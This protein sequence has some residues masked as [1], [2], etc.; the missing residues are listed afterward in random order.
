MTTRPLVTDS[1]INAAAGF[2]PDLADAARRARTVLDANGILPATAERI[3]V[4]IADFRL[5]HLRPP[6]NALRPML[7]GRLRV[8]CT[9]KADEI[10]RQLSGGLYSRRLTNEGWV[11][12]DDSDAPIRQLHVYAV[13][14]IL[15]FRAAVSARSVNRDRDADRLTA[16]CIAL[17]NDALFQDGRSHMKRTV[18]AAHREKKKRDG[19]RGGRPVTVTDAELVQ[20]R[21]EF[22][23]EQPKA[24][25]GLLRFARLKLGLLSKAL[26]DKQLGSRYKALDAQETSGRNVVPG[27]IKNRA[28]L[29][30][31]FH[32][33]HGALTEVQKGEHGIDSWKH[34]GRLAREDLVYQHRHLSGSALHT[35]SR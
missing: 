22:Y 14:A 31:Q 11:I 15:A 9:Y 10:A 23:A 24:Q 26:T 4:A 30:L 17:A 1:A 34:A 12:P 21:S 7:G 20:I 6:L 18:E 25:R 35:A 28:R 32:S 27:S 19:R 3:A 29:L 13:A 33:A 2:N 16:D 5:K 8:I